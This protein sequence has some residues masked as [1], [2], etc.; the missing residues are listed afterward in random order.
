MSD[1]LSIDTIREIVDRLGPQLVEIDPARAVAALPENFKLQDLEHYLPTP[2]RLKAHPHV[3]RIADFIEYVNRFKSG[4]SAIF[5]A[6]NVADAGGKLATAILD[7]HPAL[8]AP[9][10]SWCEHRVTLQLEPSPEYAMLCAI[11]GKLLPQAEFAQKL[12]D[13]A[14]FVR[15]HPTAELL[16]VVRSMQLMTKGEFVSET[17]EQSGSR[18]FLFNV[19]VDAKAATKSGK[20]LD[21]PKTITLAARV[22]GDEPSLVTAELLY[23]VPKAEGEQLHLGIRLPD[24]KWLERDVIDQVTA[25]I[26][27]QTG[28][29][30]VVGKPGT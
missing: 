30:T 22:Y 4:A 15:S 17:D 29:L 28:L 26:R 6:S 12:S 7:Y 10:A 13:L 14:R 21:V 18:R 19:Q 24:R 25:S 20:S 8:P 11:D 5:V 16:E 27:T 3:T 9:A 23:R 2:K 1:T